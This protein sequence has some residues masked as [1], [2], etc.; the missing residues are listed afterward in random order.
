MSCIAF[1]PY[2]DKFG[3]PYLGT[4]V[5]LLVF[6]EPPFIVETS[7]LSSVDSAITVLKMVLCLVGMC[8]AAL[9]IV[10]GDIVLG[11]LSAVVGILFVE[12]CVLPKGS[13]YVCLIEFGVWIPFYALFKNLCK[14]SFQQVLRAATTFFLIAITINMVTEVMFPIT[15]GDALSVG[16]SGQPHWFLGHKNH[17]ALYFILTT[18]LSLMLDRVYSKKISAKTLVIIGVSLISSLLGLSS[19]G[20]VVY[21]LLLFCLFANR[22]LTP[23][24]L[25]YADVACFVAFVLVRLQY[26]FS[27]VIG[28]VLHKDI[29]FTGRTEIWDQEIRAIQNHPLFGVGVN[30]VEEIGFFYKGNQFHGHDLYLYLVYQGGAL[31][32][33]SLILFIA[34]VIKACKRVLDSKMRLILGTCLACYAFFSI[35]DFSYLPFIV[36]LLSA[37]AFL[38]GDGADE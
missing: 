32:A 5:L 13:P 7:A 31:C 36:P 21:L 19:T 18:G 38:P 26:L 30:K 12:S 9:Q 2:K 29:T 33:V 25:F 24:R 3:G 1:N 16:T 20:L 35:F 23:I 8:F 28:S 17:F 6:L 34:V 37:M 15:A 4:L 10:D 27:W 22:W 14:Q 11:A